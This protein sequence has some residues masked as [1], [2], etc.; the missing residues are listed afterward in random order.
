MAASAVTLSAADPCTL[1]LT[2]A[3]RRFPHV[4]GPVRRGDPYGHRR[5]LL[6]AEDASVEG[7]HAVSHVDEDVVVES[8]CGACW[9]RKP[10][11]GRVTG[12]IPPGSPS[13]AMTPARRAGM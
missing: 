4:P 7:V 2:A 3:A 13:K 5:S 12:V 10:S 11:G 9:S 1:I 6:G 8:P